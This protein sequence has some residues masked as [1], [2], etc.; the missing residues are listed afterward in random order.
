MI[1]SHVEP[2]LL[3]FAMQVDGALREL[4][5]SVEMLMNLYSHQQRFHM[6]AGPRGEQNAIT[7]IQPTAPL[8]LSSLTQAEFHKAESIFLQQLTVYTKKQFYPVSDVRQQ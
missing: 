1:S 5:N 3:I 4:Q 6:D 8:F 7:Q 2:I